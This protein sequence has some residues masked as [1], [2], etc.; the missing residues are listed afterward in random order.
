MNAESLSFADESFD[1]V[2]GR[3]ILHHLDLD[4]S[5]AEI[6]R[7]LKKGGVAIFAE[8]MGHNP[9]LNWYRARTPELRTP[10]E[11]PLLMKDFEAARA[12]FPNMETE[13]YGL[14]TV[15]G[16]FLDPRS[17]EVIYRATKALD[18]FLLRLPFI[19]RYA[20]HCLITLHKN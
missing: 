19:K 4:Q 7:I 12:L 13:F 10:D 6:R 11:H 16:A 18:G 3:G 17:T 20:W 14:F 9:V 15:V 2:V 8:P 1:I 5:L